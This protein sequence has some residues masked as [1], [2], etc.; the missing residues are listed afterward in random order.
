MWTLLIVAAVLGIVFWTLW[1]TLPSGWLTRT[2]NWVSGGLAVGLI[3]L[4]H[5][6][7]F[8]WHQA[9]DARWAPWILLAVNVMSSLARDREAITAWLAERLAERE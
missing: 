8:P 2:V 7:A 9:V 3:V 1:R 5:L 6:Q 4:E